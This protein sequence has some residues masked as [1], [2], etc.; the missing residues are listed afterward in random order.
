MVT[1]RPAQ[2]IDRNA[3]KLWCYVSC[4]SSSIKIM[5]IVL[6][7]RIH[8]SISCFMIIN[9]LHCVWQH[10]PSWVTLNDTRK[11]N[12][13]S[14][15]SWFQSKAHCEATRLSN[16]WWPDISRTGICASRALLMLLMSSA[17]Y[18]W[19]KGTSAFQL[20]VWLL[21]IWSYASL[22]RA[23]ANIWKKFCQAEVSRFI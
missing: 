16:I 4:L 7:F 1:Q 17:L 2:E 8:R 5:H 10:H 14:L 9:T 6:T 22:K 11:K 3:H 15:T 19:I 23:V 20:S 13:E 12:R 21:A 18:W